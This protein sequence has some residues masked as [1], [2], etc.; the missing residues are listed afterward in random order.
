MDNVP[1]VK[2]RFIKRIQ[3]AIFTI[4]AVMLSIGQWSDTKQMTIEIYEGLIASFTNEIELERL[5]KVKVG[6]NINFIE[7][8]F[9]IATVIKPSQTV[10]N[11]NYRYYSD[12][13]YILTIAA[14]DNFI[15][16][17]QVISLDSSFHPVLPFSEKELGDF[18]YAEYAPYF[19]E[20]RSDNAN[21]TYYLESHS[22]GR[23][24]LFFNQF[25][26]YV[27]YGAPYSHPT[28]NSKEIASLNDSILQNG[29]EQSSDMIQSLRVIIKPNVFS[30]G[31]INAS[32]AADML[33]TRYE[34]AAYFK[35]EE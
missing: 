14:Q 11:L 8:T 33:V 29:Q 18:S 7:Q 15:K 12:S 27:A 3:S 1:L 2:P 4:A 20:L 35:D 34:Y 30:V 22:L 10:K 24:G 17:Y 21:L 9:G 19:D 32:T 6:G 26:T 28:L 16:G 31:D 13:K 5:K 23:A 25:I